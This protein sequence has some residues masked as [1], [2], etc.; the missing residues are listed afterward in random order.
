MI[1]ERV[2]A[3]FD[4]LAHREDLPP[5]ALRDHASLREQSR[6]QADVH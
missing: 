1:L 2:F 6:G 3:D 4:R 5:S